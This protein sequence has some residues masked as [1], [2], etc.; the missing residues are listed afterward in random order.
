MQTR[1]KY[2]NEEDNDE[3]FEK[4]QQR[5]NKLKEKTKTQMFAEKLNARSKVEELM[6]K[7]NMTTTDFKKAMGIDDCT[8]SRLVT[9]KTKSYQLETLKLLCKVLKTTPSELYNFKDKK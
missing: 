2:S 1:K 5:L 9:G 6:W 4:L 3:L 7:N 8:A